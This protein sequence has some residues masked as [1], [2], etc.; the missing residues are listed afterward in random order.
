MHIQNYTKNYKIAHFAGWLAGEASA[1]GVGAGVGGVG[2]GAEAPAAASGVG[3]VRC[4]LGGSGVT[5]R[6]GQRLGRGLGVGAGLE[7]AGRGLGGGAGQ[8]R[9][10]CMRGAGEKTEWT[11]VGAGRRLNSLMSDGRLWNR[12]TSRQT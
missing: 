4:C 6:R 12:Q 1:G 2:D 10:L 5:E 9:R 3:A 8:R 7:V 11:D